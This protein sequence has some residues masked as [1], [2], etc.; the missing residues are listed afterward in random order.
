MM[1]INKNEFINNFKIKLNFNNYS[2]FNI[3]YIFLLFF[4]EIFFLIYDNLFRMN[5]IFFNFYFINY[6]YKDII[7]I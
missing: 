2:S 5:D 3:I 1:I 7:N 6:F 4:I